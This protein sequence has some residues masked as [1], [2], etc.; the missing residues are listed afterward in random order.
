MN[1]KVKI[2]TL[3][4]ALAMIFSILA[5]V[6]VPVSADVTTRTIYLNLSGSNWPQASAWM[7]AW[8]WGSSQKSDSWYKFTD[9]DG[10]GYY[11]AQIPNDATGM[12]I[13]RRGPSHTQGS[14][15]GGQQWASTSD[16]SITSTNNCYTMTGWNTSGS[17]SSY[18]PACTSHNY[19]EY[20]LCTNEGCSA[21][22]T[23][24]VAGDSAALLGTTWDVA[25]T[26]NDMLY[27]AATG[28]YT[29]VYENVAAGTYLIKCAQDHAWTTSY[30]GTAADGNYQFVVE[31]AGSTVTIILKGTAVSVTVEVPH[32]HDYGEGEVTTAPGCETTG[33]KTFTCSCGDSYTETIPAAHTWANADCDTARTCTVCHITEGEPAGHTWVDADCDTAK[34][35]SVCGETQGEP[36]GH[37]WVDADCDTAKTCFVCGETEG[38]ALGHSYV[39]GICSVCG[40]KDANYVD[41]YLVGYIN[42][43]NYGCEED[44]QNLGE[45][46][47]VD[48]KLTATFS[49]DSYIF[50]KTGNLNGESVKWLLT[51]SYVADGID[52]DVVFAEGKSEKMFVPANTE[53]HFTLTVNEDGTVSLYTHVHDYGEGEIT[54][55]PSCTTTGVKTYTCSCGD[56]YTEEILGGHTWDNASCTEPKTCSVCGVTEGAAAGHTWVDANCD[57]AKTCSVCGATEGEAL[58]HSYADGKCS[59]C[60]T[61]DLSETVTIYFENNWKWTEIHVYYWYGE[62]NNSWPGVSVGEPIGKNGSGEHDVYAVTVPKYADG[63]IFNGKD[64]GS[65]TQTPDI[66]SGWADCV[67]FYM[68]WSEEQGVYVSTYEYHVYE[69]VTTDPTCDAAGSK[70]STCTI[71]GTVI[72]EELAPVHSNI[73]HVEAKAPTCTEN[74]NIEYW[75]CTDCG[76]AYLDENCTFNTNLLAVVLPSAHTWVDANCTAAKTCSVCGATE[77]AALGHIWVDADCDSPKT[78]SVCGATEGEALGHKYVYGICSVCGGKDASY[79]DYYLVGFI[80]GADYGCEGDYTNLGEYKFVDGKLTATFTNDS[81]IFVKTGNLNGENVKWFLTESYVHEGIDKNVVFAEGNSEKMF[82]P[83]GVEVYFTLTVNEDGTLTLYTHAHI[84]N[85][86]VTAP[87]CTAGGYTTYTC[88]CG[89]SYVADEVAALGHSYEAVVTAPTCTA[90]GYTTYTC[91]CGDSYVADEVAALGHNIVVD[92]AKAPTCTESGLTAGEHCTRCDHKVAQ[93][94]VDALGHSYEAVVTA[95]TCTAGGYTIHTCSNCGDSY[96][97]DEVAA[98]GHNIVVDEAKA[99]T[100]T[101]SG[102]TAGEHCTRCDHKVEQTVVDA[103]GHDMITHTEILP[104]CITDGVEAGGECTR[105]DHKVGL[106]VIEALGHDFNEGQC[107]RCG[108]KDPDYVS[109]HEHEFINGKC[110]CGVEDPNYVAPEQPEDPSD[111]PTDAPAEDEDHSDCKEE[112]SGWK[113][114]WRAIFNFF[115]RLFGLPEKC[116][117]GDKL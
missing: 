102:F 104:T 32:V 101:E 112:S 53:L 76:S 40:D 106:A 87:T 42:G 19:N 116:A 48:G 28:T 95:P 15:D 63:I 29:K 26:A 69:T 100:C 110:E 114:F 25:N 6:A 61:I 90:G 31:E 23:Y 92:E 67:C 38:E 43:A 97:A 81:Y 7:E 47:F 24:T 3:V 10:D 103:L 109:P 64:N 22:H 5:V 84:Y 77:D 66:E 117:C 80:N 41:Y 52:K 20:G 50:V 13:I 65:D 71:C 27:D 44:Y 16:I 12:K 107:T 79:V 60:G 98:L 54:T 72:T 37:T 105:C 68:C 56:S 62:N 74:G 21:G 78:C 86:V 39:Y 59:V 51:E 49:V 89:D 14:W 45:Y 18:T 73:T 99:P 75:Y 113:N 108:D 9:A 33:V 58:G 83:A 93:T 96:V 115:R 88:S 1:K 46:K 17:W 11:E 36:A 111:E 4:L 91:S 85:A 34:T 30:G 94:V 8:V 55:A 35:C 82:V 2:L 57:T 70:V